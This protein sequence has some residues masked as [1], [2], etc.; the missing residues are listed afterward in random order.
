[1]P[2]IDANGVELFYEQAG[3]GLP[4]ILQ[5]HH[6]LSWMPFQMS[7]FSQFYRVVT[8]DRR[9]TG[10][11]AS[12]PGAWSNADFAA[13]LCG[14]LDALRIDRAIVGGA[15]LGGVIACQFGLDYPDRALAL[16]IGHTVPYF[17][18]DSQ[19]WVDEQIRIIEAGGRP[20]VEQPRSFPWEESGPPTQRP[21]FAESELGRFLGTLPAGV[22]NTNEDAIRMLRAI[23]AWDTR[24]RAGEL[25]SLSM[26]ALVL[27]GGNESQK[28]ITLSYEWSQSIPGSE[29][30]ILP[31][32]HHGA[33]R[34]NPIGWNTA[35]HGFL[36]RHG[37]GGERG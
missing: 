37:L 2:R 28:T 19:L 6:H 11:S 8:F 36:Q 32:T 33:A 16:I 23:R 30:Y 14:L 29:F 3:E 5:G 4:L 34:E 22:G 15:S 17:R 26:P 35:V 25:A 20:I 9:G 18:E 12:P 31:N 13:D 7:Y 27:V 21:G 24:P 10:R 1:M